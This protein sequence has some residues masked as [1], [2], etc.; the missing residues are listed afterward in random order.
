[1]KNHDW[2]R[3]RK[4]TTLVVTTR[5]RS[6]SHRNLFTATDSK[7][8]KKAR[9]GKGSAS[10]ESEVSDG[11]RRGQNTRP[12]YGGGRRWDTNYYANLGLMIGF[13]FL[14]L[15]F[16]LFL[17]LSQAT[18]PRIYKLE[19]FFRLFCFLTPPYIYP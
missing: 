14:S 18:N 5:S 16:A 7:R 1:M 2:I 6:K 8:R 13:F 9:D 10:T 3:R 11:G 19:N 12:L 4:L 17:P 15:F